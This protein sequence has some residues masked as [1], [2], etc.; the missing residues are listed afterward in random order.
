MNDTLTKVLVDSEGPSRSRRPDLPAGDRS[1]DRRSILNDGNVV[2]LAKGIR[3]TRN[4]GPLQ[5]ILLDLAFK[6]ELTGLYN[7]RAFQILAKQLLNFAHK[8]QQHLVLFFADLDD[9]KQIND[10]FGHHEGDRALLR[11]ATSFKKTFRG[12]DIVARLGGD[13]FIALIV[14]GPRRNGDVI[15]RRLHSNVA[16]SAFGEARYSASVSVGMARFDP[17]AACSLHD[18]MAR[19]DQAMYE[20]KDRKCAAVR[21]N[22]VM[23]VSAGLPPLVPATAN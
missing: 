23:S 18:L 5:N 19:A 3:R 22:S 10:R 6:D 1:F 14:E 2:A 12:S 20:Q 13:E 7:R 11:V 4:R 9:L 8:T 17:Q 15:C 16:R 21:T